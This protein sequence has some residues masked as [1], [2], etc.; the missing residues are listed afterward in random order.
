MIGQ[1]D[2]QMSIDD[3]HVTNMMKV[4]IGSVCMQAASS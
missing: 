3:N 4:N 2:M 1:F